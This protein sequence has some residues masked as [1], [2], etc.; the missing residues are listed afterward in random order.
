MPENPSPNQI[1]Q[2]G[3]P[4]A[5]VGMGIQDIGQKSQSLWP[6]VS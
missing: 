2:K 4:N 5:H 6:R 3:L 1:I